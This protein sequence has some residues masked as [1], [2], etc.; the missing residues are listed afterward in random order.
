MSFNFNLPSVV[1][2]ISGTILL[3]FVAFVIRQK[4]DKC[5]YYMKLLLSAA[6]LWAISNSLELALNDIGPKVIISK[7]SYIGV[8]AAAPLWLLFVL[9]YVKHRW[10]QKRGLCP[11]MFVIPAIVLGFVFTNEFHGLVWPSLEPVEIDGGIRIIYG[12]GIMV[13]ALAVYSAVI[14]FTGIFVLIGFLNNSSALI[15]RQV[16]LMLAASVSPLIANAVYLLG[17]SPIE[18]VDLTPISFI[19]PGLIFHFGVMRFK[20]FDIMPVARHIL[21]NEISDGVLVVDNKYRIVDINPA[22]SGI[23]EINEKQLVGK[24]V[25][26]V[27]PVF[28]ELLGKMTDDDRIRNT[29]FRL[30]NRYIDVRISRLTDKGQG[31]G[32]MIVIRDISNIRRAQEELMKAKEEAE[33]ANDAKSRFLANVSHEIRT[34]MNG[35]IGF[36][37][38][39]S[40]TPLDPVQAEYVDYTKSAAN[41][42]L[43]L[44]N[45]ILD[46]SKAE[47]GRM[48]LEHIPMDLHALIAETVSLFEPAA[49]KRGNRLQYFIEDSVPVYIYGDPIRL[50]QVL[51]NLT[52]NAVKFTEN[53][54]VTIRAYTHRDTDGGE[55]L[56]LEVKDT[57]IGMSSQTM[58]RIFQAFTQA[59]A[60]TTR[61]YGGTGLGLSITK[62]IVDLCGGTIEVRSEPG[63]GS[64]FTVS[65]RLEP[66]ER[67]GAIDASE[68][69]ADGISSGPSAAG[70]LP[71]LP[72]AEAASEWP[73]TGTDTGHHVAGEVPE[74]GHGFEENGAKGICKGTIL[75]ADD[76]EANRRLVSIL[77]KKQG[78]EVDCADNGKKAVDM[79]RAK[80]YDLV[81]MDCQMPEM[82]GYQAARE[83]RSG[84]GINKTA[85]IIAMTAYNSESDR[86]NCRAA[87]M[88]DYISKPVRV[89]ILKEVLSK[90]IEE[91]KCKENA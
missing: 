5:A 74:H 71:K 51:N 81:L 63:K 87:G 3:S 89:D 85:P 80:T 25:D 52:G 21:F 20:M 66:A 22:F 6:A 23:L 10:L 28:T 58:D 26:D 90:Y 15:R 30:G 57:G 68:R 31:F 73:E 86:R 12:H 27:L 43:C 64:C 45:D 53:G 38:L 76:I 36:L 65:I 75:L 77:L 14:M 61:K 56:R 44:M 37:E 55:M 82:D 50:R 46:Y 62:K 33:A 78:Y 35:M 32:F 49:K 84:G 13:F 18:G 41:S 16:W 17:Y 39:L 8:C 59:D 83:I 60:S 72:A 24:Q 88:D 79:C 11:A 19:I 29:S 67:P 4:N 34:P 47:S 70:A 91:C 48:Q 7:I 40:E 42:L 1:M 9:S 69:Q 54:N 2:L